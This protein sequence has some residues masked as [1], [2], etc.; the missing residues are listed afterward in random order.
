MTCRNFIE[1]LKHPNYPLGIHG[2]CGLNEYPK[3][4]MEEDEGDREV[5]ACGN[6]DGD[7]NCKWHNLDLHG[8]LD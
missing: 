3:N 1:C 8:I 7:F 6:A 4:V 5:F 2:D